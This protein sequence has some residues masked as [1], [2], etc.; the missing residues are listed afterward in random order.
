M[1][2]LIRSGDICRFVP[3]EKLSDLRVG[4]IILFIS[5]SGDLVGHRYIGT[6][7]RE[8]NVL[9]VCKGDFNRDSDPPIQADQIIGRMISIRGSKI[10]IH[11]SSFWMKIWGSMIVNIPVLSILI[12]Y[13]I[14][15]KRKLR[16]MMIHDN[17]ISQ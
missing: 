17:E 16:A 7:T 2:P 6:T 8:G 10:E 3:I 12:Q 13:S 9:Y 5:N 11:M 14:R 4:D 15:V 1:A